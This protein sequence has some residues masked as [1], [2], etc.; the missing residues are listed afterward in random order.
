MAGHVDKDEVLSRFAPRQLDA[1]QVKDVEA[2]RNAFTSL[3]QSVLMLVPPGREQAI[4]LT[5]LE[6][7]SFIAVAG[8]ARHQ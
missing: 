5:H 7:A 3:V 4:A 8:I 1:E 2:V 6:E